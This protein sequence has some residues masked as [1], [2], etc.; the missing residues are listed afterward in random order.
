MTQ[1]RYTLYLFLLVW[2]FFPVSTFAAFN[3]IGIGARPLGLGGAFVALA[4]DSNA[5]SYNPA[6][7]G[8]IDTIHIG[9]THAQRFNGLITYN[10]V[11]GIM[12]L[13]RLG[14]IG[15]SLGILGEDSEIYQEQTL[16]FSYGKAFLKQ[17]SI[18]A[19]LVRL[20]TSFDETNEFVSENHYFSQTATSAFSTD[21]GIIAKPFIGLS[22]GVS[23][24][25][26]LPANLNISEL[27]TDSVPRN[28]RAGV[29]YRL[30]SIAAMST[31]GEAVSNLLKSSLGILEFGFRN[32]ETQI[33]TG[34]EVWVNKAIAIRGGYGVA[35]NSEGSRESASTLALG[36]S[37]KIPIGGNTLQIDYGFQLLTGTFQDNTTQRFSIN[38]LF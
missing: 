15:A 10:T 35:S 18:G 34:A 13:G 37:A 25:N 8:Y 32:G 2:L 33:R 36:G 19:N 6:G 27:D 4:D 3:A 9:A 30:E 1:L 5:A 17:F 38:L 14:S 16:R 7:L 22:I 20:A 23:V 26:L 29:A 12:P 11:A 31:Q 21:V 24:E 28:I